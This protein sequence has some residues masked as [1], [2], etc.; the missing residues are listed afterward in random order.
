M[1]DDYQLMFTFATCPDGKSHTIYFIWDHTRSRIT[2]TSA[3]EIA[4]RDELN[5]LNYRSNN[6]KYH[7]Q[8]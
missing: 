1:G 2:F 8:N 4:A 6:N 7:R 3:S 5:S